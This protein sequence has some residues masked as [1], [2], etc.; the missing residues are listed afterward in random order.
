MSKP[1]IGLT[2]GIASGKSTIAGFFEELGIP[3][4]DADQLAR[5]VVAPGSV[6]LA[7]VVET[8]GEGVL[9]AD[10]SL[11][12]KRLGALVFADE[13]ARMKLNAITH[14][15]IGALGAERIASYQ[16]N[17]APY[18]IYEAALL[19]EGGLHAG[20]DGLVVVA[21]GP[22]IQLERL[23]ARDRSS[24]EEAEGR[25]SSQLP[26][27]RKVEVADHV[28]M[29]EGTIEEARGRVRDVH[30]AILA[31]LSGRD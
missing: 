31:A 10:G 8:F 5:E 28:I 9:F 21:V 12:R 13:D 11:D 14:P 3:V 30:E 22:E 1:I 15:R 29:N 2:G 7:E 17:A 4:I 27:N 25:I 20:F 16:E 18:L 24:R 23:M 6:G 19:V 26:M